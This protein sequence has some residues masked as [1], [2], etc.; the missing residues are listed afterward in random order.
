MKL[1]RLKILSFILAGAGLLVASELQK[2]EIKEAVDKAVA[3]REIAP[4]TEI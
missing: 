3:E 1:S 4:P 2:R